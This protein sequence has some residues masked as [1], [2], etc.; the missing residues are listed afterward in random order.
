MRITYV[1][2]LVKGSADHL[3]S[4]NVR[5]LVDNRTSFTVL[6]KAL[7]QKIALKPERTLSFQRADGTC[8]EKPVSEAFVIFPQGEA[9]TPVVLGEE[10]DKALLGVVTLEI[11]GLMLNPFD[12]TLLPKQML[13][14]Q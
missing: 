2:G 13:L 3:E 14:Y 1:E 4:E 7:W 11:L 5:F 8:V 12:R 10:G 9:Y 6:P